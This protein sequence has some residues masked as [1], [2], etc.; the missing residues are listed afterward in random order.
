[1]NNYHPNIKRVSFQHLHCNPLRY[2]TKLYDERVNSFSIFSEEEQ[3]FL[4]CYR[5]LRQLPEFFKP[6]ELF[7]TMEDNQ[8]KE[9][10][11]KKKCLIALILKTKKIRCTDA[12]AL[13]APIS[14]VGRLL[15]LSPQVK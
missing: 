5:W 12:S 10:I 4:Q 2:Q 13:Q 11:E 9:R 7:S 14:Y 1:L 15:R 6:K 3:E 8:A